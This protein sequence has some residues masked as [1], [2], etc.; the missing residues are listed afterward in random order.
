V[1]LCA[2][3]DPWSVIMALLSPRTATQIGGCAN[4]FARSH[5]D[6]TV[7]RIRSGTTPTSISDAQGGTDPGFGGLIAGT[8]SL[9]CAPASQDS[10]AYFFVLDL[11]KP[12]GTWVGAS[13][14]PNSR[15]PILRIS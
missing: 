10:S 15:E 5:P 3:V 11:T 1:V 13:R 12:A 14:W 2:A 4:A 7:L 9:Q 8:A 6:F